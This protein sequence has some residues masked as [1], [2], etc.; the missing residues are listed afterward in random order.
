MSVTIS[1]STLSSSSSS[2]PNV[3]V[4]NKINIKSSTSANDVLISNKISSK[5]SDSIT[6][7]FI[8]K[9]F[10]KLCKNYRYVPS[11]LP[12]VKRIIV[13]GDIHGDYNLA[14]KLLEI[15]NLIR[16][17]NNNNKILWVGSDTYVVQVGDQIDRCRPDGGMTCD[18]KDATFDDEPSDI[19]ILKLFDDLDSQAEK[20]GGRVISLLG[21][22]ELMNAEGNMDYVSYEN[23]KDFDNYIDPDNQSIRFN[24]G[25]EARK[26]AFKPGNHIA[27]NLGCSRLCA[28]I[29]GSNLFVHGGFLDVLLYELKITKKNDL[30]DINILVKKWLLG[31]INKEY[32]DHIIGYS[33]NSMFWNRILGNI[34][35]TMSNEDNECIKHIDKVIK[36]FELGSIYIGHTP[37]SFIH[38]DGINSVCNNKVWRVDNASSK[39]FH[40]FDEDFLKTKRIN[41]NRT[42]Q[43]LEI[44]DDTKFKVLL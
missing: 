44:I 29:V 17:D 19:K 33:K 39:A 31:L 6:N 30:E 11:V 43:V 24:S 38:N 4:S 8:T 15:A 27:R 23:L 1:S 40:M 5:I 2:D 10:V 9:D 3:N 13:L 20:F 26:H 12:A 37:Q 16:I 34:P 35:P 28:V 42:P 7:Q 36:V 22:H 41:K 18:L 21:N 14:V 25:I 32:V